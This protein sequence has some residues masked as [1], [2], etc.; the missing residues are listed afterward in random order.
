MRESPGFALGIDRLAVQAYLEDAAPPLD[1]LRPEIEGPL[2]LVRQTG[3][4]RMVVS[5][6]AVFDL[7]PGHAL[8]RRRL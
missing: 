8:L 2:E 3:G 4:A 5:D 6:D 1:Q 7:D